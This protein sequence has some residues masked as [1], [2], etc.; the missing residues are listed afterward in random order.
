MLRVRRRGFRTRWEGKAVST[1]LKRI[2][3]V[4]LFVE[5]LPRSKL[6]YQD[7]LGLP[8]VYED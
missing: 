3:A 1:S 6:F 4:T 8:M 2:S 5:D 7:V